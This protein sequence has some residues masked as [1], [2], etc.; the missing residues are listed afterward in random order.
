MEALQEA[1]MDAPSQWANNGQP[2]TSLKP[3]SWHL[4]VPMGYEALWTGG[5]WSTPEVEQA[6][7]NYEKVLSYANSDAFALSWQDAG[8]LVVD[9][10]AAFNVMGDWQEGFFRGTGA[11]SQRRLSLGGRTRH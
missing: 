7:A 6:L 5:D 11:D 10:D 1:G 3:S 2:C 4:L 8:Q 9:G